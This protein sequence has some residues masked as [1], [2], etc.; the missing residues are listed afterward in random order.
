MPR[1]RLTQKCLFILLMLL[2]IPM[3]TFAQDS[4]KKKRDVTLIYDDS[5]SMWFIDEGNGVRSPSDNWKFANYSLQSL[6]ALLGQEDE[7]TVVRMSDRNHLDNIKL[8]YRDRQSEINRVGQWS[9]PDWTPF[10]T[11][12]TSIN[13]MKQRVEVDP[14][15]EYWFIIVMDG[16]FNDLDYLQVTDDK[17]RQENYDFARKSLADFTS[18]MRERD[19]KHNSILVTIES[20]LTDDERIQMVD[21]K[22]IW[23]ETTGGLR[24]TA[25]NESEIIERI[26]EVAAL[27]TNRDP[28]ATASSVDLDPRFNG[29][30]VQLTSPYPLRRITVLQQSTRNEAKWE[31]ER[32]DVNGDSRTYGYDGPFFTQTPTDEYELRDDIYGSFVHISHF[33]EVSVIPEGDYTLV[34][35]RDLTRDEQRQFTFIA[36]PAIDFHTSLYKTESDGTLSN[37]EETFFKQAEMMLEVEFVR[38]EQS[39]QKLDLTHVHIE[40]DI[41]VTAKIENEMITLQWNEERQSFTAPFKMPDELTEAEV[42]GLIRGFYQETKTIPLIGVESRELSLA[43]LTTNWRAPLDG[44]SNAAPMQIQPFVN[45]REMTEAELHGIIGQLKVS[46]EENIHLQVKQNGPLIEISPK[47]RFLPMFT[48]VGEME[49]NVELAGKYSGEYAS[50]QVPFTVEDI[51]FWAKYGMSLLYFVVI[52]TFLFWLIGI[53]RK[54]RFAKNS[55]YISLVT[56]QTHNGRAIG[57]GFTSTEVFRTNFLSRWLV[58][59]IPEKSSVQGVTF[60]ASRNSEHIYLP[61]ESQT[62]EMIV[63]GRKLNDES[64]QEDMLIFSNDV[65]IIEDHNQIETYTFIKS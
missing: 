15:R 44:L 58:P 6:I 43:P 49:L 36:E 40:K 3:P 21:F 30:E 55:S 51:S 35:N 59:Y 32:I 61:K 11:V 50:L 24:L 27:I 12:T 16:V 20:N 57:Q 1:T 2:L 5:G 17:Q 13:N 9:D 22:Q 26:N 52:A 60:K 34:F 19:V 7:L 41:E 38:S 14:T 33:D 48:S 28:N 31:L 54:P 4:L 18:F 62:P 65:I 37:N 63:N 39:F 29:N 46:T 45:G 8:R 42:T 56:Q 47:V 64:N 53:I 23:D 25:E 10:Q